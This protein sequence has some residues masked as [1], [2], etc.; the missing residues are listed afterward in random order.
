VPRSARSASLALPVVSLLVLAGCKAAPDTGADHARTCIARGL[1][2]GSDSFIH[3]VERE[4]LEEQQD[5][6]RIRRAR[7]SAR[8]GGKF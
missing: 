6:A 4:Q 2:P 5:L 1:T 3:C 7:E 8:D